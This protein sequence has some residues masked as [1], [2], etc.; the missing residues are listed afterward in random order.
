MTTYIYKCLLAAIFACVAFPFNDAQAAKCGLDLIWCANQRVDDWIGSKT[1]AAGQGMSKEFEKSIRRLL[2]S[3]VPALA[4]RLNALVKKDILT[5]EEAG[6]RLASAVTKLVEQ[7]ASRLITHTETSFSNLLEQAHHDAM[8]IERDIFSNLERLAD[9]QWYETNCTL[10]NAN[11]L[12]SEQIDHLTSSLRLV[13][14]SF[15]DLVSWFKATPACNV[16]NGIPV[17]DKYTLDQ[18]FILVKCEL[19]YSITLKMPAAAIAAQYASI[20]DAANRMIC[21][22]RFSKEPRELYARYASEAEAK[23]GLWRRFLD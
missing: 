21:I 7:S 16:R 8:L 15:R 19:E 3:D 18:Q 6:E 14:P 9:K 10:S 5:A 4:E 11:T 23:L 2:A 1:K 13:I 22:H 20:V 12:V 17:S